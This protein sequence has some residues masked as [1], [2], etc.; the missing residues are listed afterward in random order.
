MESWESSDAKGAF[1][2]NEPTFKKKENVQKIRQITGES[3]PPDPVLTM[4]DMEKS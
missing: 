4:S 1:N 2:F 3:D